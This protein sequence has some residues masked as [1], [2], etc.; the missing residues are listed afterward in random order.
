MSY[1]FPVFEWLQANAFWAWP[2]SLIVVWLVTSWRVGEK[3]FWRG[4]E[5]GEN[6]VKRH[7]P[8]GP[9]G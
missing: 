9:L 8:K 1:V 6:S 2:L 7:L 5:C 4:W 3:S